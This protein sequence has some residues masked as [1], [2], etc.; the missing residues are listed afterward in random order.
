[1]NRTKIEYVDFTWNPVT[2]CLHG[3]PYCFARR[4]AERF[5]D[6]SP[7]A[8][9]RGKEYAY[10]DIHLLTQLGKHPFPQGF[11]LTMY[12][13]RLD[14]PLSRRKPSRIFVCDMGDLFGEWVPADWVEDVLLTIWARPQHTFLLLTKNPSR[15]AEFDLPPNAWAGTSV[16]NQ[17]AAEKRIP[18]LLKAKVSVRWLSV[19]PLLGPVDLTDYLPCQ[20]CGGS[21]LEPEGGPYW[22]PEYTCRECDGP[23][24]DAVNWVVVGAQTGPGAV[25]PR[26]EW[27][28]SI[29]GQCEDAG[30]PLFVKGKIASVVSE[31]PL[32][33]YPKEDTPNE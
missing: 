31:T 4:I 14:E 26:L 32:R 7:E 11:M 15:Y 1:M 16:E 5:R 13:N 25:I 21:G 8:I 2:G 6:R 28:T 20:H 27:L 29:V 17:A 30:V 22:H 18:E 33:Q 9:K 10:A 19:E 3:C 12:P 23:P 24:Y